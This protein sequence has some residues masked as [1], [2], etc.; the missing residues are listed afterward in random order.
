MHVGDI[1]LHACKFMHR[2]QQAARP[3]ACCRCTQQG[4][5]CIMQSCAP[6]HCLSLSRLTLPDP[7]LSRACFRKPGGRYGRRQGV[8]LDRAAWAGYRC[9]RACGFSIRCVAGAAA[10]LPHTATP[11]CRAAARPL[12][13]ATLQHG[14]HFLLVAD[15]T[16]SLREASTP[17]CLAYRISRR[18]SVPPV[19]SAACPA[20]LVPFLHRQ[21]AYYLHVSG[22]LDYAPAPSW[23]RHTA[24]ICAPMHGCRRLR[25][26]LARL[27]TRAVLPA[28]AV[29]LC[30]SSCCCPDS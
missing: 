30:H 5:P 23:C 1:R 8:Y 14:A 7:R 28:Q 3:A 18:Y 29:H 15:V 9:A 10:F 11:A 12:K 2:R 17:C 4:P 22:S 26:L 25:H 24:C 13:R 20:R 27:T 21:L 16:E 19:A 6:Q